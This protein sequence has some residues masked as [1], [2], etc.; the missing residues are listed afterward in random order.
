[1]ELLSRSGPRRYSWEPWDTFQLI[2]DPT[3]HSHQLDRGHCCSQ[4]AL[5]NDSQ[6][7]IAKPEV[8]EAGVSV[9]SNT[10]NKTIAKQVAC[11]P[12]SAVASEK[13][14]RKKIQNVRGPK[15]QGGEDKKENRIDELG[16]GAC[17]GQN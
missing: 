16:R 6:V 8:S 5:H 17:L 13:K 9:I 2:T 1:M 3:G 14:S 10:K 7:L 15:R 12:K 11:P 4:D